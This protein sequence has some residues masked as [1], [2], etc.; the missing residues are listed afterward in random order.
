MECGL[1]IEL[2]GGATTVDDEIGLDRFLEGGHGDT[3]RVHVDVF[4]QRV[5]LQHGSATARL[6]NEGVVEFTPAQDSGLVIT[7][8]LN[9]FPPGPTDDRPIDAECLLSD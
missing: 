1:A 9:A 6:L 3:S 2:A 7:A 8:Q 4:D 5:V